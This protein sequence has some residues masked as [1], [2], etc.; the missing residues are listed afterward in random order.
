VIWHHRRVRG[1]DSG[2]TLVEVVHASPRSAAGLD[3][4]LGAP[5]RDRLS[6]L[7]QDVDRDGYATAHALLRLV[8][9]G[10]TG[11]EP[12]ALVFVAVCPRCGAAHGKPELEPGPGE[13]PVHVSLSRSAGEVLVAVTALGPVGVDAERAAAVEFEGFDAFALAPSE[14]RAVA[15]LT[16]GRRPAGRALLWARKEAVLKATGQGLMVAPSA[17]EVSGPDDPPALVAWHLDPEVPR[18]IHLADIGL[19]G[20]LAGAVAVITE[21]APDVRVSSGLALLDGA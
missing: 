4:L 1:Q 7:R 11:R 8:V 12:Q 15:A 2:S 6:R 5:E 17:V 16:S 13:S 18:P 9:A 14:R 21:A 19:A 20:D 3:H 10:W